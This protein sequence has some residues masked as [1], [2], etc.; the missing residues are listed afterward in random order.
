MKSAG[1]HIEDKELEKVLSQTEGLGTEATRAGI[2]TMLK[3]RL[4]IE[5]NKNLVYA[6]AK[7]KI[8]IDA[9][10]QQILASPEMTAKWEQRLKE[11]SQGVANPKHFLEQTNKMVYHLISASVDQSM[12]WVF[13]EEDSNNFAPSK[14]KSKRSVKLGP[15]KKCDGSLIDKGSFY[16]CSNFHKNHCDFTI[17]KKILGKTITQKNVKKLLQE[18]QTE[19]IEGFVSKDKSF[20]AILKWDQQENKLKFIYSNEKNHEVAKNS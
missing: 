2:I 18:G 9:V 1:K 19:L 8:L 15:C 3:D 5:V 12:N 10:G 14:Q 20:N 16:G 6:T 4:Y 11:I 13:A 17:S 7:A